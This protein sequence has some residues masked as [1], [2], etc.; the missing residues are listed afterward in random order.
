[1]KEIGNILY[2]EDTDIESTVE[3]LIKDAKHYANICING[4][5]SDLIKLKI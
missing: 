1:M 4:G 5:N 3:K 2:R